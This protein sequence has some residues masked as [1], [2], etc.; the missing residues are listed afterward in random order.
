MGSFTDD[1]LH[2][3]KAQQAAGNV[4]DD[5]RDPTVARQAAVTGQQLGIPGP[6]VEADPK[7]YHNEVAAKKLQAQF[8][9]D[10]H[11]AD[12]FSNPDNAA[13]AK[14][15][16]PALGHISAAFGTAEFAR[17]GTARVSGVPGGILKSR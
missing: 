7:L 14:D 9:L 10:P 5:T 16:A 4:V 2:R 13:V 15:D 17:E 8:G 1:L 11:M 3:Y 12:F 6:V